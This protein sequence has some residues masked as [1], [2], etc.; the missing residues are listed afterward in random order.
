MCKEEFIVKEFS[1]EKIN[2]IRNKFNIKNDRRED[3]YKLYL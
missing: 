1:L 2:E 3:I